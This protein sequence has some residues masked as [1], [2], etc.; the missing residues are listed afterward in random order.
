MPRSGN[1]DSIP[2]RAYFV[3]LTA[4]DKISPVWTLSRDLAPDTK[5]AGGGCFARV[6]SKPPNTNVSRGSGL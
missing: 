4:H 5:A 3:R 2:K 6:V 1:M